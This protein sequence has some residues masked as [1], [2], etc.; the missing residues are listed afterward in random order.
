MLD[1]LSLLKTVLWASVGVLAAITVVRFTRGLGAVT[2]LSD[3]APW[4]LWIGFDVMAGVALAAGGFVMAATVYIF[5]LEKYRPC[6]RPAILTALLGYIAVA[7]GLLFDLGLPW[8]IWHPMIY[9]QHHSVLFEV[10]MCVMLYLS[11]L[12]LEFAPVVLEHPVFGHPAF[13]RVLRFLRKIAIPIVIAGIVLSTLHQSSLGSLFLIAPFRVHPLWYSPII[14]LLF[15]VSAVGLGLMTVVLEGLLAKYFLGHEVRAELLPGIGIA[16]A[17]VLWTYVLLRLGDLGVRGVLAAALDGTWQSNLFLLEVAV[18][19]VLP[20]V[21]LLFRRV[22]SSIGGMAVC[23]LLTM[24]GMIGY[25]LNLS[26][27][28]FARPE[29]QGYFPSWAEIAVSLGI[30]SCCVLVFLFFVERLKVY[31]EPIRVDPGHPSHDAATLHGLLPVS[32]AAPRRY[33]LVAIGAA[34]I[35][36]LALPLGGATPLRTSVSPP[37]SLQG[38]Q[39]PRGDG[40]FHVLRLSVAEDPAALLAG[41]VPLLTVDGNRAG[42][43]V[44][45][46]HDGHIDREGGEVS[47]AGCHHLN[48]PFD[49]STSCSECHRDM[50]EAT[51]LFSHAS[52]IDSLGEDQACAQCHSSTAPVKDLDSATECAACHVAPHAA[53]R[54]LPVTPPRWGNAPGYMDAMH[55]LCVTCH[56]QRAELEPERFGDLLQ[57]CDTCHNTDTELLLQRLAPSRTTSRGDLR[58]SG[59]GD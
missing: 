36:L 59:G 46:N 50:Y 23:A 11:V 57:R 47:C 32:V 19:A 21:L 43:L 20:A 52:H 42:P 39:L 51:P 49:R 27:V 34:V 41:L 16:A 30:V 48:L 35:T 33:S 3:A 17:V 56:T 22:R 53:S 26:I 54:V 15:F 4:G 14:Y 6:V 1:R 10:G 55:G 58:V 28:T 7:V 13:Q 25:R 2:N 9:W 31:E 38:S 5:G 12:S 18:A 8:N 44:L 24:M 40:D 29:G 37:R 45:F